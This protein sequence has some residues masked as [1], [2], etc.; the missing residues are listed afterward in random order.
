MHEIVKEC[1]PNHEDKDP[2]LSYI[3]LNTVEVIHICATARGKD[4]PMIVLNMR[5]LK[6][7]V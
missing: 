6:S 2:S 5:M 1:K 3:F 7:I 4:N